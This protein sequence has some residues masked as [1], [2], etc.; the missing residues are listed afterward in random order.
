[1]IWNKHDLKFQL[2]F[3]LNLHIMKIFK[4]H[5]SVSDKFNTQGFSKLFSPIN[6]IIPLSPFL[7][8]SASQTVCQTVG[9]SVYTV[10][11]HSD[12]CSAVYWSL[13]DPVCASL[14]W[15]CYTASYCSTNTENTNIIIKVLKVL[16]D[17]MGESRGP[18]I[19]IKPRCCYT[20]C[21][22]RTNT[23]VW[24]KK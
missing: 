23:D 11:G 9:S 5:L 8:G 6:P 19:S 15:Y 18:R 10:W 4:M 17:Q 22:F 7:H 21:Q 20:P 16:K 14:P 3:I 13:C 24:W 1:M 12:Q 2:S